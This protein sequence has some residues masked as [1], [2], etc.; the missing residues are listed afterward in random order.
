MKKKFL[1]AI[2][3]VAMLS[4]MCA[5]SYVSA[6]SFMS[7]AQVRSLVKAY[8]TPQAELTMKYTVDSGNEVEVRVVYDLLLDKAPV[9]VTRFIQLA[10]EGFYNDSVA[11]GYNT[12]YNYLTLGRYA[13]RDST[14]NNGKQYFENKSTTFAGEFKSNG[15]KEPDGGYAQFAIFS[16][17]MYHDDATDNRYFDAADGGL[18]LALSNQTLNSDNYAVFAQVHELSVRTNGGAYQSYGAK[19]PSQIRDNLSKFTSKTSRTVYD[20]TESST[21]QVSI[22]TT[23]VMLT[24]RILGDFDWSKLPKIGA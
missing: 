22:M 3:L 18:I 24:V 2:V 4:V 11:D 14:K 10:N 19:I 12:T 6:D 5:C 8:G 17:A 1:V 21:R 16:L 20:A 9:A 13:Y 23:K 15:Y 7:R